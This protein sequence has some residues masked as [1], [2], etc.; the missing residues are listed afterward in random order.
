MTKLCP[1]GKS[2]AKRKFKV[3]PSAYANAYA[4]KICAGKIKDPSGVKRKDFRGNKAEGGLMEAT[5]RLKRQGLKMG[6][7][8][9]IQI[10]GF[11]KARRPG[12]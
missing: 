1:R 10:K 6:G 4:S 2:A 11:G 8:A 5:S 3:Y 12:R 9:C 7:S